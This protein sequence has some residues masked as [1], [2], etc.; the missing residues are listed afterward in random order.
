M[1]LGENLLAW[2]VLAIGAAMAAGN[3]TAL[4]RPPQNRQETAEFAKPPIARTLVFACGGL[5]ISAWA[6]SSLFVDHA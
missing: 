6:L 4:I 3:L 5:L 1:F 2:L